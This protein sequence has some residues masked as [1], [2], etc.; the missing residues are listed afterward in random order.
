MSDRYLLGN[1]QPQTK[2]FRTTPTAL[3]HPE[4]VEESRNTLWGNA[5]LVL[6]S[7]AHLARVAVDR[8]EDG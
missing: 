2:P 6:H 8:D 3:S 4:S 7:E 5:A 1:E